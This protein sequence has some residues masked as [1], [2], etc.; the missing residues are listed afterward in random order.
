[1]DTPFIGQIMATGFNFAP[2]NWASCNGQTVTI[3]GNQALF[4]LLGTNFGG[5][6]RTTF[7][8]PD[9]RGR[10]PIHHGNGINLT[11][12]HIGEFGGVETIRLREN[13]M[14]AHTHSAT[15]IPEPSGSSGTA[16]LLV[17]KGE[18]STN[19]PALATS[20]ASQVTSG[21]T[22]FNLLSD[23]T[24]PSLISGAV[25]NINVAPT[26]G[27]VNVAETGRG[28]GVYNMQ[29]Y[30]ALHYVIALEGAFP[31]RN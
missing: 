12:R 27:T 24:S 23:S 3:K 26:R 28:D 29:P 5:D 20:M 25:T 11:P 8:L 31:S 14:P 16:D 7:K 9:L 15:F 13:D 22:T 4:A 17:T 19:N 18:S 1:M 2:R 10:T 6:G 21:R 30:L